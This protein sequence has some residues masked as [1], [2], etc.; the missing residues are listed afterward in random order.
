M[1]TEGKF[2]SVV[3]KRDGY[4]Y[5]I[6]RSGTVYY[7]RPIISLTR[8]IYCT[9]L[10]GAQDIIKLSDSSTGLKHK[11]HD[12]DNVTFHITPIAISE[13]TSNKC[14]KTYI[15]LLHEP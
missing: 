4:I 11:I 7:I 3:L 1:S 5:H 6:I 9:K 8:A 2:E 13:S 15:S 14:S 12:Q 10:Q